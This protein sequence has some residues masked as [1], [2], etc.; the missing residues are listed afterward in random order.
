MKKYSNR[1]GSPAAVESCGAGP[2]VNGKATGLGSLLGDIAPASHSREDEW[3]ALVVA[4]GA[5]DRQALR[6]IYERTHLIVYTLSLQILGER[7]IA[8]EATLDVYCEIRRQ[9]RSHDPAR[10]S[11]VGWVMNVTRARA[12]G[13]LQ[14]SRRGTQGERN[15]TDMQ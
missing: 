11:V 9:A 15:E 3:I 10:E 5:G 12:L 2:P 13:R 6:E 14:D 8:E 7:A 4:V 1:V